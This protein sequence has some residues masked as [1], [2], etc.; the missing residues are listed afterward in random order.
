MGSW[1]L[2]PVGCAI[3]AIVG[4]LIGALAGGGAAALGSKAVIEAVLQSMFDEDPGEIDDANVGDLPPGGYKDGDHVVVFGEHVYDGF[5][6]GWHEMHPLL[7]IKKVSDESGFLTWNP[8]FSNTPPAGLTQEDMKR[9]MSSPAFADRVK[10]YVE[11]ECRGIQDAHAPAT[12]QQQQKLENRWSIHP[13][14]D[15]CEPH[16]P[17]P[18]P[19]SG[20]PH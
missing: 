17:D 16:E 6:E 9:G 8:D 1:C 7:A 5:H 19:D 12:R 13:L 14:V 20:G 10:A 15:G 11:R 2:G 18:D 4:G 3:G